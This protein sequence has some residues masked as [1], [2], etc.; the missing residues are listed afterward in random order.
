MAKNT[1]RRTAQMLE[2]HPERIVRKTEEHQYFL[3]WNGCLLRVR[4]RDN[5]ID[6]VFSPDSHP[7]MPEAVAEVLASLAVIAPGPAM[8]AFH[9]LHKVKLS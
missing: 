2:K 6:A 3:H 7:I 8:G 5:R 9:P 1:H 4:R